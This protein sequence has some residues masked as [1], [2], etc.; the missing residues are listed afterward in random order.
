MYI[1]FGTAEKYGGLCNL[2]MDDTNPA[3]EDTEYV[4]AIQEDIRWLGFDWD[5]RFYYG[6]DYFA[7]TYQ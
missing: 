2:S 7:Q 1:D 5:D 4:E 3:K 6:S